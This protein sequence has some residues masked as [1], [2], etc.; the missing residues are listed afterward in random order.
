MDLKMCEAPTAIDLKQS[1]N[2]RRLTDTS[3]MIFGDRCGNG[4]TVIHAVCIAHTDIYSALINADQKEAAG[5]VKHAFD[6]ICT[7]FECQSDLVCD[8]KSGREAV[9]SLMYYGF[10]LTSDEVASYILV[11][12]LTQLETFN[13]GNVGR[14]TL[15]Y[16]IDLF[17]LYFLTKA[18]W[19]DYIEQDCDFPTEW[20]K[21]S[22]VVSALKQYCVDDIFGH[23]PDVLD[24][25]ELAEML[26]T[27]DDDCD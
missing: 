10:N 6:Y 17:A 9:P 14:D 21:H 20:V 2:Y 11:S 26:D 22:V 18:D 23:I 5:Q 7:A 8:W 19:H 16:I 4:M 25:Y 12:I 1:K 24:E 13:Y 3:Q 27:P 15:A